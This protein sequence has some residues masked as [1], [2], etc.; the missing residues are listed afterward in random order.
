MG[1]INRPH[2]YHVY[3]A[4]ALD[5][6]AAW[7]HTS[8]QIPRNDDPRDSENKRFYSLRNDLDELRQRAVAK[9]IGDAG[10]TSVGRSSEGRDLLALKLGQGS[11]HPVLFA[12]CHHAREWI[13]V[14]V[15]YLV[16]EY[17]VETYTATPVT[18]QQKRI[19]HLLH[20]RQIW[21]VPMVNPDG[22]HYSVTRDR[23]WR[24][25]RQ[26]HS[27]PAGSIQRGG[28][29]VRYPAGRYQGVDINRNYATARWGI[30][31]SYAGNV[32]TSR[33][34][35]DGGADS[36]WCGPSAES[37]PETQ[38]L[39]DLIRT[40]GF[41]AA[42]TYHS[43]SELLLY[44]DAAS[45][46]QFVQW[47]GRGLADLIA[48]AGNPYQYQSGS[49][50]YPVHGD[51]MDYAWEQQPGRPVFTP[52][53]RPAYAPRY[54]HW[55]FSKLPDSQIGPCFAE[56]LP[57]ALAL[58]NCAG[59]AAVATAQTLALTSA[60]PAAKGQFVRHCWKV[61]EGWTI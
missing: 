37:E 12:G 41:R 61:F 16:A 8:L 52:E 26:V 1:L 6:A 9:G 49:S 58:I 25:A 36:V 27:L 57:A 5:G 10:V 54:R 48:A 17:L 53:L 19:K 44:P 20:N 31:T 32:T 23:N 40:R 59:H 51:M 18:P 56:N 29:T 13:S 39:A 4:S 24:P 21:F 3:R 11:S 33:D 2:H 35:R 30:E 38:A 28:Q 22:H 42:I 14:E 50:L 7:A 43:F 60:R 46:D 15:P 34:P 55:F 47:V 45:N